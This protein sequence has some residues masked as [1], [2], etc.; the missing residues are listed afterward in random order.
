MTETIESMRRDSAARQVEGKEKV[1]WGGKKFVPPR[2]TTLPASGLPGE[3]F[4]KINAAARD[5][6]FLRDGDLDR[7]VT[8]GPLTTGV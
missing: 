6:L 5:Q 4:L 2:G 8:V 1:D 7:W 3:V